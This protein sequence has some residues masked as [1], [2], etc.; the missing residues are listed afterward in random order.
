MFR[1][2]EWKSSLKSHQIRLHVTLVTTSAQVLKMLVTVK[3]NSPSQDYS[4]LDDQTT[5]PC[6]IKKNM[7]CVFTSGGQNI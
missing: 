1:Q 7:L 2:P 4:H 3:D 5:Q 6:E